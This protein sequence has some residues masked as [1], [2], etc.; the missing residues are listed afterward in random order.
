MFLAMLSF[1]LEGA[2]R[3]RLLEDADAEELYALIQANR[4]R[5]ERWMAW[6]V[7]HD[8]VEETRAFIGASREQLQR[9]DGFQMAIVSEGRIVGMCGFHAV[10]WHN[11]ATALGYW[12]AEGEEGRGTMTAAVRALTDHAFGHWGLTRVEIRMDVENARSRAVAERLG[13]RY[14]GTL[15]QAYRIEGERYSDDAVYAMLA[16]QWGAA[17]RRD[18]SSR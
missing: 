13:F 15:H 2:R 18:T 17:Q 7:T 11:R 3:L 12:L 1:D 9:D 14:E 6:A 8:T 4:V 16:S 5:L 10:D